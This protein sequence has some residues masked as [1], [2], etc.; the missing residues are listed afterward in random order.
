MNPQWISMF[1]GALDPET[2]VAEVRPPTG[3]FVIVGKFT[4]VR[5]LRLLDI[6][7]FQHLFVKSERQSFFDPEF[8]QLRDKVRFLKRLV[9]IMSR[10]VLPSDEDYHYLP[11]QAVAEYLSEKMEPQ[12]D[13]L[14]FPSSQ[15]GG[16]GE[17]VV[18]FRH[19]SSVELDASGK[20]G[21]EVIVERPWY[22]EK[23]ERNEDFSILLSRKK[24]GKIKKK[25]QKKFQ[26]N[27]EFPDPNGSQTWCTDIEEYPD[28]KPALRVDLD[29]LEVRH[30]QAVK[31]ETRMHHVQLDLERYD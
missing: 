16:K 28:Q 1:Y 25:R 4:I 2:S 27:K 7:A 13:G 17:N 3:S 6:G 21:M 11:I 29:S 9:D 30:I 5:N 12:L 24:V 10:P 31:Y 20:M 23:N 18:L 15:R 19:V 14:V 8:G 22:D 26:N